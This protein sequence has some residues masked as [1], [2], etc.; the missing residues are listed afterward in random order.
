[1]T[2]K[3]GQE[4]GYSLT[5]NEMRPLWNAVLNSYRKASREIDDEL[6]KTYAKYLSTADPQDY[7]NIMIRFD[8]LTKLQKEVTA[9]YTRYSQLAG[10][11]VTKSSELAITNNFYRQQ[12]TLA[13]FSPNADIDLAFT[14]INENVVN[15]SVFGTADTWKKIQSDAIKRLYGNPSQYFPQAGSLTER[16][17]KNRRQEIARIQEAITS[18]LIQGNSYTKLTNEVKDIIGRESGGKLT[19]AKGSAA[20]I[21]RTEGTRNLNSGA[22]AN[23]NTAAAQGVDIQ[24]LWIATLDLRT[25]GAHQSAD[26]KTAPL[27]G[28]FQ[29]N[30]SSGPAPGQLS[31][32]SQNINCRCS[33]GSVISGA[34]PQLRAGTNPVSGEREIFSYRDYNTWAEG[35]GLVRDSNR[36]WTRS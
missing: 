8:R 22:L 4:S 28:N 29:V 13:W 7:Y 1:M 11:R 17:V 36:I 23:M 34:S 21:V 24:K 31:S 30:G 15:A 16:L 3:T 6:A 9:I 2:F 33:L 12:Y 25:R 35:A 26:G 18:G 20:R 5:E 19:G 10:N 32:A 14:F 27:N